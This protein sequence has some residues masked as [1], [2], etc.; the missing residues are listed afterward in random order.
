MTTALVHTGTPPSTAVAHVSQLPR[1]IQP[2]AAPAEVLQAQEETR[3]LIQEALK[4]GRDF[5]KIPG[6][7]KPS[8]LKPGA[9]RVALAF[10]CTMRFTI[11]EKEVDHDRTVLWVKRKKIY[12]NRRFV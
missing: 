11:V 12:E 5:G 7:D 4:D 8:L 6:V 9:E 2:I 1:L 10:G 3:A